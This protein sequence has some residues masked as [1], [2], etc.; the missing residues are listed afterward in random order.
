VTLVLVDADGNVVGERGPF[1]APVPW[2]QEVGGFGDDVQVLRLLHSDRPAPPG[3]HVT[4]LAQVTDAPQSTRK[5][6]LSPHPHR[7]PYAEINGPAASLA[8]AQDI[9]PRT[10][11]HQVRTW[12]LSAIWRLD[13]PDGAPVAWLKQV[14]RFFGHEARV[15]R[16]LSEVAPGLAPELIADGPDGRMLLAHAPGEDRYGAGADICAD[17]AAAFH[18]VQAYF[19]EHPGR[20]DFIPDARLTPE[21]FRRVAEPYLDT[22]PGL[23]ELIDDLP[24]RIAAVADC[25]LPDTLVHGDL[26][27]GNARTDDAGRLTIMDWGDCTLGH[28]G[29]DIL[30]L[31]D[32]LAEPQPLIDAWARRWQRDGS[33]PLRA[34]ELL[35]P[36]HALRG[37]VVYADFL[38]N[39][40]P[41]EFPYHA[42]D[43]PACLA[44]AARIVG[45]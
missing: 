7:A 17:I 41:S 8:W 32:D 18:P 15:I 31:T 27:P 1:E 39:I 38:D 21:P 22:V 11:A 2:W 13:G 6:P 45:E 5:A 12:N 40:E 9:L 20:L 37:A 16:L 35:R 30:R 14:P 19:A 42:D 29:F 36:L 33:D 4:Y 43:V 25:G 26:H 23:R 10:T 34:L 28:P 44:T 24:R 3:G